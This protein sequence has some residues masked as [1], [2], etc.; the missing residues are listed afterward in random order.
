MPFLAGRGDQIREGLFI[1]TDPNYIKTLVPEWAR[2]VIGSLEYDH[3]VSSPVIHASATFE[4]KPFDAPAITLS[5]LR[6]TAKFLH[7]IWLHEDNAVYTEMGFLIYEDDRSHGVHSN[8]LGVLPRRADGSR[9]TLS[10]SRGQLAKIRDSFRTRFDGEETWADPSSAIMLKG[11]H[12]VSRALYWV[13]AAR[14]ASDVG[15]RI[16]SYC[17]AL[18]ALFATSTSELAHQLSERCAFFV[19]ETPSERIRTYR[20]MKKAYGYRSRIV[21]G[22]VVKPSDVETMLRL[23]AV[24]G[25]VTR[26]AILR[27]MDD[28]SVRDAFDGPAEALDELLLGMIFSADASAEGA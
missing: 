6:S 14:C 8:L 28:E 4:R 26:M 22:D 2:S 12:R 23:G 18:E 9:T 19:R 24:C 27:I 17:S 7:S 21:H 16:S 1:T 5:Y 13:Q 3:L 20:D 15:E 11:L 25:E 10:L